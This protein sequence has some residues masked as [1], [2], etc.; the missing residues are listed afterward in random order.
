M[1]RKEKTSYSKERNF[2]N[3]IV[4]INLLKTCRSQ[5]GSFCNLKGHLANKMTVGQTTPHLLP[6][7]WKMEPIPWSWGKT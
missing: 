6:K 5:R 4:L 3:L 7:F 2:R 1:T